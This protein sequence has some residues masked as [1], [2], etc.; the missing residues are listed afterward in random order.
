MLFIKERHAFIKGRAGMGVSM[1]TTL[2]ISS[3]LLQ[4][5]NENVEISKEFVENSSENMVKKYYDTTL[6]KYV[7]MLKVTHTCVALG[8]TFM[9]IVT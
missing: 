4:S 2:N 3:V 1:P 6:K 9:W 5:D 8:H 7:K